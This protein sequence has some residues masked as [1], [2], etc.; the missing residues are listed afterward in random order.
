LVVATA[1]NRVFEPR[2]P[3]DGEVVPGL[4]HFLSQV[5]WVCVVLNAVALGITIVHLV[6]AEYHFSP[7]GKVVCVSMHA[8][9]V[10]V[11]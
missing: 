11:P 8:V 10:E 2:A 5:H 3:V 4:G 7:V 9:S 6:V 1:G